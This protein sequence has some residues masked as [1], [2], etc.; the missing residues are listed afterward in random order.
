MT[1]IHELLRE[2]FPDLSEEQVEDLFP[3]VDPGVEP[4]G[5]RVLV[6][7]RTAKSV[8]K[9]GIVLAEETRKDEQW[10]TQVALVLKLG[11]Y[12]FRDRDGEQNLEVWAQPG[13]LVRVPRWGGD[14]LNVAIPGRP[15]E[16]A[17]FCMFKD[18]ELSG[19]VTINPI[20]VDNYYI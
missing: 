8:S 19:V 20:L 13:K 17:L 9:G 14:R 12:A 11:P 15:H 6:Q 16:K 7:I 5:A 4:L 18:H 3:S 2:Q 1:K 10:Q